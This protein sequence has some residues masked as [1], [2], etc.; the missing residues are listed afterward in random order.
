MR[1]V[2]ARTHG[3]DGDLE[4]RGG[5]GVQ[6]GQL[7]GRRQRVQYGGEAGVE[8]PLEG[9]DGDVN[10]WIDIKVVNRANI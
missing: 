4:L 3:G 5:A 8:H 6:R 7:V 9:Q 10:G 1:A 2:D